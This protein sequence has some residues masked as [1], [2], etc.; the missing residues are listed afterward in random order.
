VRCARARRIGSADRDER[1]SP[2]EA[3]GY[4]DLFEASSQRIS[5]ARVAEAAGGCSPVA[6][7][8]E[9]LI[10][11]GLGDDNK[12]LVGHSTFCLRNKE[13]FS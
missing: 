8:P 4:L 11:S 6:G 13:Q 2:R 9:Q 3:F 5:A 10:A 7:D 1:V 12:G